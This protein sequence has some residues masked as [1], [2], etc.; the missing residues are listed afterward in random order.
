MGH[1]F[2]KENGNSPQPRRR[3]GALLVPE[4]G[5]DP[6]HTPGSWDGATASGIRR[7][8]FRGA[9]EGEKM[10]LGGLSVTSIIIISGHSGQT[11]Q[12]GHPQKF[13]SAPPAPSAFP[14]SAS[15][16]IRFLAT[17]NISGSRSMPIK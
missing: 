12:T 4:G 11:G 7:P 9:A 3:P 13:F 14:A 1:H 5:S 2:P 16:R 6:P 8:P 17:W 15:S 10:K